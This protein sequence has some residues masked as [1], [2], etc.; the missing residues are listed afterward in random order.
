MLKVPLSYKAVSILVLMEEA[1]RQ[2]PLFT[3]F[4][5][6]QV[7]ILVLMEEALRLSQPSAVRAT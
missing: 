4:Q 1:L 2:Q 5:S 7:S 6:G 3:A